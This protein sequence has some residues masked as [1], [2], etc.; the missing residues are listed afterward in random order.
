MKLPLSVHACEI[1]NSL[2]VIRPFGGYI[3]HEQFESVD[4]TFV[5]KTHDIYLRSA[6]FSSSEHPQAQLN[7]TGYAIQACMH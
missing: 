1:E 7:N 2:I 5:F 4:K 6:V 3:Q